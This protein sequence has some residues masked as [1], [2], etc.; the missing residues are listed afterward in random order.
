[1]ATPR[2]GTSDGYSHTMNP[3]LH[4]I[5][6]TFNIINDFQGSEWVGIARASQLKVGLLP[7]FLDLS[8]GGV[9]NGP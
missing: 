7:T 9:T 1:M 2:D 4:Q 8:Y 3:I 6:N 5:T